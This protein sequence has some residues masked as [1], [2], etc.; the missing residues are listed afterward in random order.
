MRCVPT[1]GAA[2]RGPADGVGVG[3]DPLKDQDNEWLT[4]DNTNSPWRGSLHLAWTQFDS[5]GSASPA[6][7][8]RILFSH[9]TEQGVPWSA[10][11]RVIDL[12]GNGMDTD[13]TMEGAVPAVGPPGPV[14]MACA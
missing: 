12:A 1:T 2:G 5:L 8:S 10:P 11:V 9:S 14:Y 6:D 7:S 13:G 3:L 4:A